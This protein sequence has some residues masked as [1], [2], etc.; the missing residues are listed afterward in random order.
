M[1]LQRIAYGLLV[2]IGTAVIL[3]YTKA[4]LL[5]FV[6]AFMIWFLIRQVQQ[7][8]SKVRIGG[9]QVPLWLRGSLAF[10]TIFLTLGLVATLLMNNIKGVTELLP[11]YERNVLLI[12][13]QLEG[14]TGLNFGSLTGKLSKD[15]EL[16]KLI[17]LLVN[18][19]T[20]V[21]GDAVMVLI[22]VG[23]LMLEERHARAKF[24]ALYSDGPKREKALAMLAHMDHA[25]SQYVVLKT[26]V[27]LTTGG[28]SYIA[29]RIIGVDFAFFWAFTIFILNYIPT[30]GSLLATVFPAFIA[31]LQFAS[32]GPAL[33]VL[34]SVGV[35]QVIVGNIIDPRLM[36]SSLN[37]SGVVVILSLAFWGSIWG[38]TGMILSVPIT[39]MLVIVLAQ[40]DNTRWL[41]VLL[42]DKGKVNGA[43]E[44]KA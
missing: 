9:K 19:L 2:V 17:T 14:A 40:F 27:S 34:G 26:I 43:T 44:Q 16:G 32:I 23:F 24:Q 4:V 33:W 21:L 35:I 1:D 15:L 36:G 12:K 13:E 28:L 18:A 41:A 25:L 29:L 38:V 22:Y 10:L 5:P 7:L 31:A 39:V 30:I 42:S 8:M 37:V 20:G 3:S 11:H 6:L